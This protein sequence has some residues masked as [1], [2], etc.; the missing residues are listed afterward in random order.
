MS[1]CGV[2]SFMFMHQMIFICIRLVSRSCS[3]ELVLLDLL[4]VQ[5]KAVITEMFGEL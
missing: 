2:F 5:M 4:C 3:L 1:V